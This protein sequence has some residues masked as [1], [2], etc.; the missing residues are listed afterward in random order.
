MATKKVLEIQDGPS[1]LDL[2]VL[3]LAR[4]QPV[5]FK[6]EGKD[7]PVIIN[8]ITAEDGSAKKWIIEGFAEDSSQ[9]TEL[10]KKAPF[11]AF[12]SYSLNRRG[13]IINPV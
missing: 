7:V 2:F 6:I 5:V 12:Y 9:L 3:G 4:R 1:E 11:R 10:L 13:H 8:G